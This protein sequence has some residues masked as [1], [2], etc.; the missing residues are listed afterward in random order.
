MRGESTGSATIGK[1]TGI[2]YFTNES[3]HFVNICTDVA[4]TTT[5]GRINIS[6]TDQISE[7]VHG[8]LWS[9]FTSPNAISTGTPGRYGNVIGSQIRKGSTTI[10]ITNSDEQDSSAPDMINN[11]V[12][13]SGGATRTINGSSGELATRNY[14]VIALS[15]YASTDGY[16]G[17]LFYG[18]TSNQPYGYVTFTSNTT[19]TITRSTTAPNWTKTATSFNN[20]DLQI[21]DTLTLTR[22]TRGGLFKIRNI[23][24]NTGNDR[25]VAFSNCLAAFI[26][27]TV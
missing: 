10:I 20:I 4:G 25:R 5:G 22:E 12:T 2:N 8:N 7:D 1:W 13:V 26:A 9:I 24:T 18:T 6:Q 23:F 15:S 16:D 11:D 27:D 14:R 19:Y 21:H 17:V 3:S